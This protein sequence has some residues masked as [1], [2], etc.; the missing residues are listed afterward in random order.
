MIRGAG[1]PSRHAEQNDERCIDLK[2]LREA[3]SQ[4][5]VAV[6]FLSALSC[7]SH[8]GGTAVHR[9]YDR[10]DCFRSVVGSIKVHLVAYLQGQKLVRPGI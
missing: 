2:A 1:E 7:A 10:R 5:R 4:A 8:T 9:H 3:L 6:G